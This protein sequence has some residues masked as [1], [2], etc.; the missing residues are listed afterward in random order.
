VRVGVKED[1]RH[2]GGINIFGNGFG[3]HSQD[4]V[5]RLIKA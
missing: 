5:L 2:P 1:A 3:N 4:I